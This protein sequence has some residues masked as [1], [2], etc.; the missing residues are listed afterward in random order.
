MSSTKALNQLIEDGQS[1]KLIT[2]S[3]GEIAAVRLSR[4]KTNV[5]RNRAFYKEITAI[6]YMV[7]LIA[8]QNRLSSPNNN[9]TISVL[10]TSNSQF[11]GKINS[12]LSRYFIKNSSQLATDRIVVGKTGQINM[13]GVQE[14][15][16]KPLV[17]SEDLPSYQEL[18]TLADAIK[19][20]KRVLI[21]YSK[22]ESMLLQ[23]PAVI[24]ITATAE[25]IKAEAQ[26]L[27]YIFEPQILVVLA[28]FDT[29]INI[30]LLEQTLLESELTRVVNRLVSMSDAEDKADNF[31][32]QQE[33]LLAVAKRS[34][35]NLRVL[36]TLISQINFRKGGHG[37]Y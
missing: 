4:I 11:A 3:L 1:L 25:N 29:Q 26:Q 34:S 20:Y 8:Q 19:G 21:Y 5:E 27:S 6:Y 15:P 16:F 12:E 17:F 24:D 23:K 31:L 36:E 10:L 22:M 7:K 37:Q 28:F 14:L 18:K 13:Q 35:Y 2:Q 32:N 9:K 30:L 33:Q